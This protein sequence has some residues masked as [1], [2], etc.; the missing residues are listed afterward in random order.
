MIPIGTS[1]RPERTPYANYALILLNV[2]VF[3]LSSRHR[4]NEYQPVVLSWA[5]D[6]MLYPA[7]WKMWQ[8]VTYAFLHGG[9]IHLAGNMFFLYLFG[10]NVNDKLGHAKYVG[11]YFAGAIFSGVGHAMV[12]HS[13]VVG[14]LGASGAVA[15]VTGAY[16]V[17]FPKTLIKVLY[18]FI[19]IGTAEFPAIWFILIKLIFID[20]YI[21]L[22]PY[23]AYDA[24]RS[25]YAFGIGSMLLCLALGWIGGSHFDLWAMIQRWNRRRQYRDA[26]AEGPDPFT[27]P[28]GRRS[29]KAKVV[30]KTPDQLAKEEKIQAVRQ[31]ISELLLQK[32]LASAAESYLHLMEIDGDQVLP[33][34]HL[35]DIA[36]QLASNRQSQAAARAY[37]Q[38]L[39]HYGGYEYIEQVMLMVG[40]IYARYLDVPEKA[41][42]YLRKAEQRLTDSQQLHM[43]REELARLE[44]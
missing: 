42:Q 30:K 37:E 19:F 31:E 40:I 10:N 9:V 44:D 36:N 11:F 13:S 43:C 22:S 39:A 32:N 41:I 23:V 17:L 34:Q 18:F 15:A 33:R 2:V 6:L 28:Y 26:V 3:L 16:L 1:I 4:Q 27:G 29:V 25:G 12:N 14:T 24:H 38:F 7:H 8:F 20:N 21:S 5:V 35:L